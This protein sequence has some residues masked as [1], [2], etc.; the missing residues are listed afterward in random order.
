MPSSK[1][2]SVIVFMHENDD[3]SVR[4]LVAVLT[5]DLSRRKSLH[6]EKAALSTAG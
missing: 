6:L 3:T 5:R 1:P 4:T 2:S